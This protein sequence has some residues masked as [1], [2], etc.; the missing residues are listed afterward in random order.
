[1]LG[2]VPMIQKFCSLVGLFALLSFG[3]CDSS[4]SSNL[5][6]GGVLSDGGTANTTVVDIGTL[7]TTDGLRRV[8]GYTGV[9]EL[10]APVAAGVDCDGDS[11][12]DVA[13]ASFLAAPFGRSQAGEVYLVF[14]DGSVSGEVDTAV[15]FADVLRIAGAGVNEILGNE[16]W[17]DDVTGDGIGDLILGR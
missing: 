4:G 6:D 7:S 17:M 9:G 12:N 2:S 11:N 13:L 1:M 16:V 8:R 5:D 15:P 3:A 14:G 10:G